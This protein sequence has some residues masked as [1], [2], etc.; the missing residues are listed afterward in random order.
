[1]WHLKQNLFF[2]NSQLNRA[3]IYS[4]GLKLTHTHT[5]NNSNAMN[6]EP[7]LVAVENVSVFL[8]YLR[9][10]NFY[11]FFSSFSSSRLSIRKSA[12]CVVRLF[13][14]ALAHHCIFHLTYAECWEYAMFIVHASVFIS[15]M[16]CEQ[17][18]WKIWKKRTCN[19]L[20]IGSTSCLVRSLVW[21]AIETESHRMLGSNN[22]NNITLWAESTWRK[23]E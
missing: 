13:Y 10:K 18:K 20:V 21:V 11:S 19:L 17:A 6:N 7:R 16:R 22:N 15:M 2:M 5:P 4:S 12:E 14:F 23:D 3:V 8:A 9:N 1:M